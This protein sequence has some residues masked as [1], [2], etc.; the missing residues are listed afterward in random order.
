MRRRGDDATINQSYHTTYEYNHVF[1]GKAMQRLSAELAG[2][3][4]FIV[5]SGGSREP[6]NENGED[7]EWCKHFIHGENVVYS[8]GN[9]TIH[10]FALMVH[11]DHLILNSS[12][13]IGWW[14]GYLNYGAKNKKVIVGKTLT[15]SEKTYWPNTFIVLP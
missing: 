2:P 12:S 9:D 6:G 3:F 7:I 14:A 15:K 10:D 13:S 4:C 5:F 8:E 1:L 11:C